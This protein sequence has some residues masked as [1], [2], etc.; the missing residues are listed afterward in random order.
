MFA[1]IFAFIIF[2]LCSGSA[3]A[4]ETSFF[5]SLFT[6]VKKEHLTAINIENFATSGLKKISEINP[7]LKFSNGSDMVYLY[8]QNRQIAMLRK[9]LDSQDIKS[10][11]KISSDISEKIGKITH[12]N[13]AL[14]AEKIAFD[15]VQSLQDHS[16]YHFSYENTDIPQDDTYYNMLEE[17]ILYIKT[18]D[19]NHE[20]AP[21]IRTAL[22]KYPDAE[23]IILD[24]RSNQGGQINEAIAIAKIF[25]DEGIIL[26]TKGKTFD[27]E[28]YY[29]SDEKSAISLPLAVL[30]DQNTASS[31]E[32]L[33]AALK[34]QAQAVLI[35][36]TSFGKGSYQKTYLFENGGKL[37]LT[38]G[39]YFTP[40]GKSIDHKG[41]APDYCLIN[42]QQFT[43]SPCPRQN[44]DNQIFDIDFAVKILTSQ[45]SS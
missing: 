29:V 1:K 36:S 8:A 34:E 10:W 6:T 27:S 38:V 4:D 45:I 26:S 7:A 41:L 28:K 31:A 39:E 33:A 24:L 43:Q 14:I 17:K 12:Q 9:P 42:N 11:A 18:T 16:R 23:G 44:R 15:S 35:G 2:C 37:A 13:P 40:S 25:I 21:T 22:K 19:F 3:L 32:I 30:I 5:S 20:N